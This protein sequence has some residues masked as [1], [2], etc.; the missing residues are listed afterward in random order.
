M[1]FY[2]EGEGLY[3]Y[4]YCKHCP[5][6]DSKNRQKQ[7]KF[8]NKEACTTIRK[9]KLNTRHLF[10]THR[11]ALEHEHACH[12]VKVQGGNARAGGTLYLR[13]MP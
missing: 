12:V 5:K 11:E 8:W 3:T 2:V 9:E 4:M 7:F 1:V 13:E 6:F 10:I